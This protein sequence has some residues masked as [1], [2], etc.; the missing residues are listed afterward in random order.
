[1][2]DITLLGYE[3]HEWTHSLEFLEHETEHVLSVYPVEL[4]TL[5]G[6]GG[7]SRRRDC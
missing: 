5:N 1:M 4:L 2:P 7:S 6:P 3:E